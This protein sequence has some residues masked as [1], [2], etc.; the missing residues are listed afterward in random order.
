MNI[1]NKLTSNIE[2][3]QEN[4]ANSI[5]NKPYVQTLNY[6]ETIKKLLIKDIEL[7][8]DTLN[9]FKNIVDIL[10]SRSQ[11]IENIFKYIEG[12]YLNAKNKIEELEQLDS[13]IHSDTKIIKKQIK[14]YK[15]E[16]GIIKYLYHKNFFHDYYYELTFKK[17][18]I[19]I[20]SDKED[21]SND[22]TELDCFD[23]GQ[24]NLKLNK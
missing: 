13:S 23:I 5:D 14:I 7:F 1:Y 11:T 20:S 10:V 22:T 21:N 12:K 2:I 6:S 17:I 24:I 19:D 8:Q 4:L 9:K 18:I 16:K 3:I 15:C